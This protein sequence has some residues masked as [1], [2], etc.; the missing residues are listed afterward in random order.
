MSASLPPPP[1][2][3]PVSNNGFNTTISP[4]M[5]VLTTEAV[6]EINHPTGPEYQL[7]VGEGIACIPFTTEHAYAEHQARMFFEMTYIWPPRH[8]SLRIHQ[9]WIQILWQP[10]RFPQHQE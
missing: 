6:N 5:I 1:P 10:H 7:V 8:L 4:G 2:R 3:Y 9:P